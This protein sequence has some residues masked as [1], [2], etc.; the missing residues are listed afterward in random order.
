MSKLLRRITLGC[1]LVVALAGTAV[2]AGCVRTSNGAWYFKEA[3]LP[4]GWPGLSPVGEVVVQELPEVRAAVARAPEADDDSDRQAM[5]GS[6][7]VLFEHIKER[8]IAMTTPVEMGY[9][10]AM[11][12]DEAPAMASM[13]FLYRRADLGEAGPAGD[14]LVENQPSQTFATLGLRGKYTAERFAKGVETLDAWFDGQSEY[15]PIGPPR[16][17]GYNSPFVPGFWRYGQVQR[18][19]ERVAP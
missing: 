15:R 1:G 14:V 13:A 2:V 16:Y 3:P 7:R 19:V 6:F 17:L 9:T 5:N 4:D 12:D 8:E 18:P 11:G 10:P